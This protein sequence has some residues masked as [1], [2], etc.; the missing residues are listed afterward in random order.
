MTL[1]QLVTMKPVSH[2]VGIRRGRATVFIGILSHNK[3]LGIVQAWTLETGKVKF[4]RNNTAVI[5]GQPVVPLL[6]DI[7]VSRSWLDKMDSYA[8][9]I[10]R[11]HPPCL[12]TPSIIL[13][14]WAF[15]SDNSSMARASVLVLSDLNQTLVASSVI[16]PSQAFT[17]A[18][19]IRETVIIGQTIHP[20]FGDV[21][22]GTLVSVALGLADGG[23]QWEVG[24]VVG[25][26]LGH[27]PNKWIV[28]NY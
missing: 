22:H 25:P 21:G 3:G 4:D 6:V 12:H 5:V 23:I 1:R 8:D 9:W 14:D 15:N 2:L 13:F 20:N 26:A 7:D 11:R 16:V 28:F 18:V 24:L 27:G 17:G 10:L 19:V